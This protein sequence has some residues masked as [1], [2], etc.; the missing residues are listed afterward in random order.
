MRVLFNFGTRPEAIKMAP[1]IKEL[2]RDSFFQVLL[3]VT[4]QHRHLLDQVLDFYSIR[5]DYD[6][7]IMQKTQDLFDITEAS[8]KQLKDVL[9]DSRPEIVIV[10][11][12]TTTA[13]AGALSAYYSK[14]KIAHLEAGLRSD[15]KY[16][17]FPEEINR[18]LIDRMADYYFAHTE[19]AVSNLYNEGIKENVWNTGNTVIDALHAGLRI[20]KDKN[21]AFESE[22]PE[23]NFSRKILLI[24]CHRRESRGEPFS[25]I[26]AALKDIAEKFTDTE[27]IY[28][29]HP[30]PSI[31]GQ[32]YELLGSVPG[33]HLI[34]PL[35]YPHMIW[36]MSKSSL[37]LTDSGGIQE[38]APALGKPVLVL[39]EV[40]E[41]P[42]GLRAG[43]AKLAG[44]SRDTIF[45]E[46][47]ELL[48]NRAAYESMA[49]ARN[50][51]GDGHASVYIARILRGIRNVG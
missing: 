11:G 51:Y 16:V 26:C 44:T 25:D 28:P 5:P 7:N 23:V 49:K 8:L 20:I 48:S 1:L 46:T 41:R 38:E 32:A 50:P 43:C 14:V 45:K 31:R 29:V 39:R 19:S 9:A 47:S 6:C 27:L 10:Q 2:Q 17:P 21:L 34:E 18:A 13:F 12:D 37:I 42:E 15:K 35:D 33:V 24:T 40:T 3:C 22:F 36:L 4:G 30:N